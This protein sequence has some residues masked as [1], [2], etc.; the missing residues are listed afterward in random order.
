MVGPF[1]GITVAT[2][3]RALQ[4][5]PR[6]LADPLA[7]TVNF[8]RPITPGPFTIS[9]E[10]TRTNRHTQHWTL[11]LTQNGIAATA[12]AVFGNRWPTWSDTEACPPPAPPADT[13]EPAELPDLVPWLRNYEFRFIDKPLDVDAGPQPDSTTTLWVRDKPTRPLD[14]ASLAALADTFIPRIMIRLGQ[15]VPAGTVSLTVYFHA[16]RDLITAHAD[17]PILATAR[18]HHL[19][20]G[21]ADQHAQLWTDTH[22]LL[23][24]SHQLVYFKEPVPT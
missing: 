19:G 6:H 13:I 9:T 10:P 8:V 17:R 16:D 7:I 1:G 21:Y 18:V 5:D 14:Y 11:T 23:A 2:L 15:F 20:N 22:N 24:T 4:D 12:T 3:L